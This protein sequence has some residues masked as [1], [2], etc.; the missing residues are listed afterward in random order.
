MKCIIF[1]Q[2]RNMCNVRASESIVVKI[3]ALKRSQVLSIGTIW[4]MP[5]RQFRNK[6]D[7]TFPWLSGTKPENFALIRTVE[8]LSWKEWPMELILWDLFDG[9]YLYRHLK[10][11]VAMLQ[12]GL[13]TIIVDRFW[14]YPHAI[15]LTGMQNA[16]VDS[17]KHLRFQEMV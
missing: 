3:L 11:S 4:N 13:N 17:G 9:V 5:H 16:R 6:Q 15:D 14:H 10:V 7:P 8:H 12:G 1:H 2:K